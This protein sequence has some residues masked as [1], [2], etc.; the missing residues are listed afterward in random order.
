MRHYTRIDRCIAHLDQVLSMKHAQTTRMSPAAL[1]SEPTLSPQETQQVIG[2]MRVDHA[3][4]I[5]AQGL[6]Q[7]QTLTARCATI[8]QHM[9]H[10]AH[11]E[12]DHLAWCR[13]RLEELGAHT[14]YLDPVWYLGALLIG[15]TTG[16]M[17][18]AWS[19]GFIAETE[20]QVGVHLEDHLQRLPRHDHKSRAILTQ[21]HAE[22]AAHADNAIKA[23]AKILPDFVKR[24]MR[25]SAKVM[26][27]LAYRI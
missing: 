8:R 27:V 26:V 25:L 17:G 18:D 19:L 5:A 12:I 6:Y 11:E 23:G 2:L 7:G 9:Q 21:M 22:E 13:A 10:A 20:H 16:L 1:I 24:M 3:G 4:E 15:A 14:S